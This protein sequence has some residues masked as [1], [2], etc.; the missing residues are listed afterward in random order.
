MTTTLPVLKGTHAPDLVWP[1]RVLAWE[2]LR[3]LNG[4]RRIVL[5]AGAV[6]TP[7]ARDELHAR[8]IELAVHGAANAAGQPSAWGCAQDRAYAV[9]ASAL[10]A[11]GREQVVIRQ[12]PVVAGDD[13]ACW[14]RSIGECVAHGTCCGGVVFCQDPGLVSCVANKIPG[15]RAAAVATLAQ[16]AR[17]TLSLGSN[18]LAVE[19]PGR[20]FFEVRQM[21]RLLCGSGPRS[22]PDGLVCTLRELEA[23]AHR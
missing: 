23:H 8:G 13:S 10:Q 15:L 18:L 7:L 4:Q 11:L 12:L 17:A 19:M 14:A 3:N 2:H 6:V 20:T 9:V 16:A 21:I 22:C 5:Q 1:G